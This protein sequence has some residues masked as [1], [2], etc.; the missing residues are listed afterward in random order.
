MGTNMTS[1]ALCTKYLTHMGVYNPFLAA[2]RPIFKKITKLWEFSNSVFAVTWSKL[3]NNYFCHKRHIT[4]CNPILTPNASH[5]ACKLRKKVVTLLKKS[6]DH[7]GNGKK[8]VWSVKK[9]IPNATA[10][11]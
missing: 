3:E 11:L 8:T 10:V 9:L 1:T 5:L 2:Y 7:Y 6:N 4:F